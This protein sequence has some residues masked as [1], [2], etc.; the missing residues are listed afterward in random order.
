M[1]IHDFNNCEE[2]ETVIAKSAAEAKEHAESNYWVKPV[3]V[4]EE[5]CSTFDKEY[6]ITDWSESGKVHYS[7]KSS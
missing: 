4:P 2:P 3:V 1:R 7:K 5:R 6:V